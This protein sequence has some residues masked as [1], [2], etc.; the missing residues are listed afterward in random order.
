MKDDDR[1]KLFELTGEVSKYSGD[2]LR[3]DYEKWVYKGFW[4]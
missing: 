2:I 4:S 3:S 1:N